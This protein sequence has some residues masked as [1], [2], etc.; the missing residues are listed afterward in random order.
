MNSILKKSVSHVLFLL[1]ILSV[2]WIREANA[3]LPEVLENGT[4]QEQYEFLNERTRVYDNFRAVRE[5]MFQRIRR[6]SIDSL[7]STHRE[8]NTLNRQL[9]KVQRDT[10]SLIAEL[11]NVRRER[12]EAISERDSLFI[13]GIPTS[14]SFYN[15]LMWSIIGVLTLLLII[16]VVLYNRTRSITVQKSNEL[17]ELTAEYE[18]YRKT[19]RE[20]FEQQAIDHFNEMNRFKKGG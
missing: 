3:Q 13:L 10:D 17:S 14:K 2:F 7:N 4:L 8:I 20:R 11:Q 19:S 16:G 9:I 6:N 18:N 12:D 5:D 15:T 1:V